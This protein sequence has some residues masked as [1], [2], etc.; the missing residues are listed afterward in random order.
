VE[1]VRPARGHGQLEST[2]EGGCKKYEQG[3]EEYVE[4]G[5]GGQ[6]VEGV[7]AKDHRDGQA[8][9]NVGENDGQ[10]VKQGVADG[11]GTV[12]GIPQEETDCQRNHG[13]YA[14]GEQ[15]QQP[16]QQACDESAPEPAFFAGEFFSR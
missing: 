14:G 1:G 6:G 3:K 8:N 10:P 15:G 13:K 4:P 7:G 11:P 12:S 5:I 16:A 9:E 2:E